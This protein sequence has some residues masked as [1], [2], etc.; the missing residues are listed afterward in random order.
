MRESEKERME[1][2]S[3]EEEKERT[4][5]EKRVRAKEIWREK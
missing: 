3:E 4:M 1:R 2:K 5:E